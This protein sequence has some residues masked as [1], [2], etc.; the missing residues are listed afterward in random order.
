MYHASLSGVYEREREER[1]TERCRG[2]R[3]GKKEKRE[4]EKGQETRK[5]TKKNSEEVFSLDTVFQLMGLA[6]TCDKSIQK[7]KVAPGRL[8]IAA[9]FLSVIERLADLAQSQH[10]KRGSSTPE[11]KNL[12]VLNPDVIKENL[13]PVN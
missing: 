2:E 7:Q 13:L 9:V 12:N 5:Q 8:M 10:D 3:E 4:K 6:F 11:D 1:R